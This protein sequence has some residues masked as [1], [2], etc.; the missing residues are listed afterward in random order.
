MKRGKD[1]TSHGGGGGD[2]SC[3]SRKR[4]REA[5]PAHSSAFVETSPASAM[6]VRAIRSFAGRRKLAIQRLLR[7]RAAQ[8]NLNINAPGD[9]YEQEADRVAEQVSASAPAETVQRKCACGGASGSDGECAECRDRQ[10]TIQRRAAGVGGP[11]E[12]PSVIGGG[13]QDSGRGRPLDSASELSRS[14]VSAKTSAD[15]RVIRTQ[16]R[17]IGGGD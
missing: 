1:R 11:S 8:A 17:G 3:E 5:L 6:V 14:R 12:A 10:L 16:R 4:A 2:I 9:V 7:S 13:A 15:V